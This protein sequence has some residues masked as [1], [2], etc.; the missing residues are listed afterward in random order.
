MTTIAAPRTPARPARRKGVNWEKWGWIYMRVSG[1]ILLVLIFGH[2]FVNLMVG[3]GIK[4]IDFAFVGGKLSNPF[5]QWWDVAMLWLALI[6]G[7]NG[8]RTIVNDYATGRTIRGVLKVAILAAVSILIILGT[9]V[10]F[11][12]DPCPAGA[13]ADLLASFCPAN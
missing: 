2:L 11:T 10:V 13:P 4:A 12:F 8:M 3:D 7:G 5:W 6:H 9:L 1:V